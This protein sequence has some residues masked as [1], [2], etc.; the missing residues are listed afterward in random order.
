M[1]FSTAPFSMPGSEEPETFVLLHCDLDLQNVLVDD[2]GEVTGILDWDSCSVVPRSVGY[3]S[4]PLLLCKIGF[5]I[6]A[7]RQRGR[8][9]P[10]G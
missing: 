10:L 2:D 1:V 5:L 4:L 6:S 8:S 7:S 3:A 9:L